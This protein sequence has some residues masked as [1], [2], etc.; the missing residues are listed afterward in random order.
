MSSTTVR[1]AV[2][3][4]GPTLAAYAEPRPVLRCRDA[5]GRELSKLP[6]ALKAEPLAQELT[7]PAE[8][9]GDHAAEARTR[10]EG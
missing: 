5:A 9:L 8:W 4:Y 2:G 10:V 6:P 1:T 7:A 3:E